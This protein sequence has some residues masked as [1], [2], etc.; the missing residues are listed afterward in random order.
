MSQVNLGWTASSDNVGVTGYQ[1]IRNGAVLASVSG[2]T[3]SFSDTTVTFNTAY[4]YN[5]RAFDAAGNFSG[6]SNGA[7]VTTPA[8]DRDRR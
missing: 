5:V 6:L 3:L 7:V 1:I 8:P 2:S 4:T